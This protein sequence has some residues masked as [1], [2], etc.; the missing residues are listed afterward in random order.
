MA[1]LTIRN[2]SEPARQ[3]LKVRAARNNR[4]MEAEVR[5]ILE[6]VANSDGGFV[7]AWLA[8]ARRAR[9]DD[10]GLPERSTPRAVDLT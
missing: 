6:R 3:A 10:L 2:L 5:D 8:A 9:G 4:S 1:T 7:D